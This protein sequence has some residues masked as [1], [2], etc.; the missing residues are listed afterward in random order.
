MTQTRLYKYQT[1]K[2]RWEKKYFM[3]ALSRFHGNLSQAAPK[4]GL[5]RRMLIFKIHD[6]GI[7]IE[8][9]RGYQ[10]VHPKSRKKRATKV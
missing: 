2:F 1:A 4:I 10:M 5:S 9:M 8:K 7:D 6:L 3:E